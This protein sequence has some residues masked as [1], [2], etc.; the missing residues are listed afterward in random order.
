M[1]IIS[2]END[3][4]RT[5][6]DESGTDTYNIGEGSRGLRITG[7]AEG[8]T[9]NFDGPL[10]DY[11]FR[12]SGDTLTITRTTDR[13]EVTSIDLSRDDDATIGVTLNFAP[14]DGG[15]PT[16]LVADYEPRDRD[17]DTAARI[18][19]QS[20]AGTPVTV[21]RQETGF[22][23]EDSDLIYRSTGDRRATFTDD[24][25]VANTYVVGDDSRGLSIRGGAEDD[26]VQFA[27][28]ISDYT[29]RA[30]GNT[31]T[32]ASVADR[33]QSTSIQLS[34]EEGDDE[35]V[36]L[37]FGGQTYTVDYQPR[38][39]DTPA[40]ISLESDGQTVT[41]GRQAT[42]FNDDLAFVA[43]EGRSVRITDNA[44]EE[45]TYIV[46]ADSRGLSLRGSAGGDTIRIEGDSADYTFRARGN[47]LTIRR[48][49][50]TE[51]DRPAQVITVQLDRDADESS[52]VTLLF[53]DG[54][55][56]ADYHPREGSTRANVTLEGTGD[57]IQ[58]GSRARPLDEIVDEDGNS[59]TPGLLPE[60]G[61][62]TFQ[63]TQSG[64]EL[65]FSGETGGTVNFAIAEGV[66]L[67]TSNGSASALTVD[68]TTLT[69]VRLPEGTNIVVNS[70]T[71][72]LTAVQASDREITGNGAVNITRSAGEQTLNVQTTG[73]NSIEGGGGADQIQL[74]DG[75]DAVIVGESLVRGEVQ[76]LNL[77]DISLEPGKSLAI[78][79]GGSTVNFTNT[80][81]N[82]L[83]GNELAAAIGAVEAPSGLLMTSSGSELFIVQTGT[84]S[85]LPLATV[86]GEGITTGV[87]GNAEVQT[88]NL[89]QA[90]LAAGET[91][92]VTSG[93]GTGAR[94]LTFTNGTENALA[95]EA[96]ATA[97]AEETLQGYELSRNGSD[98][99]FTQTGTFGDAEDLVVGGTGVT[100]G[101]GNGNEVQTL[102][103]ANASVASGETVTITSGASTLTFNNAG[104]TLSGGALATALAAETLAGFTVEADG[105]NLVL[106]QTG[107]PSNI[108]PVV[109][110]G[111]GI[112]N[113]G[114]GTAEVQSIDLNAVTLAAGETFTV[115]SGDETLTFTNA[116]AG[117]ITGGAL[118]SALANQTFTGFNL[119]ASGT[120]L[121]LTQT[122]T[123]SDIDP[124]TV[125]G[126]GVT[127]AE[128]TAAAAQETT[129]G[130]APTDNEVTVT[131]TTQ[132]GSGNGDDAEVSVVETTK[133]TAATEGDVTVTEIT[134]GG[135]R[136]TADSSA[137]GNNHDAVT[138]FS[139]LDDQLDLPSN[140]I[141]GNLTDAETGAEGLTV[142]VT[143]G[144]ATFGGTGAG[145]LP[146]SQ[147]VNA[148]LTAMGDATA[149]VAF[150]SGTDTYVLA[151][152]GEAGVQASDVL[153]QLV[154]VQASTGLV[155][156]NSTATDVLIS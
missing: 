39:G 69:G 87:A 155:T 123:P 135:S 3:T 19:L 68:T 62:S 139:L 40:H 18:S 136:T 6:R 14:T 116:T 106:T 15:A 88:L 57:P 30:S 21:A 51:N 84:P 32:I 100:G 125:G 31:V 150:V 85:D 60:A 124:V 2:A 113:S 4:R 55:L 56:V 29:F 151:G 65:D 36:T 145:D 72:T 53:T 25:N 90:S 152:D 147:Q 12:A 7:E 102:N 149:V 115:T 11:S 114:T 77:D 45:N 64:S 38:S 99:V 153:V 127:G 109:V 52:G 137:L 107:T 26:T 63:L 78:S 133:G 97:V 76:S 74:G 120:N 89:A 83:S 103:F 134:R 13:D 104:G 117:D 59:V 66:V 142:S 37:S 126:T 10:S 92:T 122:G 93:S 50:D 130:V 54:S 154:G 75:K 70:G 121:T 1:A 111:T 144:L 73:E 156:S 79:I 118:A 86:E 33:Q 58:V 105:N 96:L 20:G 67:A 27:G 80:G 110:G 49:A 9:L 148:L 16:S 8:D 141:M 81:E 34:R 48:D 23:L 98:L 128:L 112:S 94:T 119:G 71:L 17:A 35:G 91:L 47:T 101:T 108:A 5:V 22:D 140:T 131:E 28:D 129:A 46:P 41:L 44:E 95:G 61:G 138:G 43:P 132:G 42:S 82:A 146:L 143:N 24:P